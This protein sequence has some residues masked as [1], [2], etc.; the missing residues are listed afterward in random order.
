MLTHMARD[1]SC[2]DCHKLSAGPSSAGPVF[3]NIASTPDGG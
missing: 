2:A 3:L 1:G